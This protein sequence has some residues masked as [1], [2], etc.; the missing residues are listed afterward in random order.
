MVPTTERDDHLP[1]DQSG[2]SQSR[3]TNPSLVG[4]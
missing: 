1:G 4:W 3:P 2:P